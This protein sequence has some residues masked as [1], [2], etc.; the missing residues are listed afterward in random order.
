MDIKKLS[1]NELSTSCKIIRQ[2]CIE[3][4]KIMET[5]QAKYI[6]PTT[7]IENIERMQWTPY[8]KWMEWTQDIERKKWMKNIYNH[9]NRDNSSK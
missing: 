1:V 9:N 6:G 3:N 4:N 5:S 7:D 2:S 8:I